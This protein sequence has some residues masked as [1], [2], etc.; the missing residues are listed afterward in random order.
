MCTHHERLVFPQTVWAVAFIV[1]CVRSNM[2]AIMTWT[3]NSAVA[4]PL[5]GLERPWSASRSRLEVDS[6][7]GW[8]EI[9]PPGCFGSPSKNEVVPTGICATEAQ[10]NYCALECFYRVRFVQTRNWARKLLAAATRTNFVYTV[11]LHE[12]TWHH[13]GTRCCHDSGSEESK[14]RQ[15]MG[16]RW[17]KWHPTQWQYPASKGRSVKVQTTRQNAMRLRACIVF[18]PSSS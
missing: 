4:I 11:R 16:R 2:G 17:S 10:V 13:L 7:P 5:V 18:A 6:W 15:R 1:V 14:P 3:L 8:L 12:C 9:T